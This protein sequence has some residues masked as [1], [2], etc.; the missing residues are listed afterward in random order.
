MKSFYGKNLHKTINK[1]TKWKFIPVTLC[2]CTFASLL[3]FSSAAIAGGT[4]P[5]DVRQEINFNKNWKFINGEQA[6]AEA[7]TFDDSE[8]QAVRLP[9]DW[10]IAGPFDASADGSTGKLPWR[11]A[12]WYRKTF[13]L[14]EADSGKR[15]YFNFDGVMAFPKVYINGQLA[16]QWDYGYTP[17][18]IDATNHVKFGQKNTIAVMVD[19]RRHNSRWYPGAGIYRD[20]TMVICSQVHVEHWGT[21]VTAPYVSDKA[22]SV[23]VRNTIENHLETDSLADIDV[24]LFAPDGKE[25]VKKSS[26]LT[27]PAGGSKDIVFSFNV[28]NPQI[29]DV[30]S[31]KLYSAKTIVRLGETNVDIGT[32]TFGIRTFEFTPDNG[33]QLNGRRLQL[34]GVCLHHDLGPLGSAFNMRAMEREL[35]IMKEMGVNAIRTSHNPPAKGLIE[36]CNKM[37]LVVIDEAFDKWDGTADLIGNQT[38][39]KEHGERHLRNLVMRDRN[40]PSV[41][42]WS[43]GNEIGNLSRSRPGNGKSAENV[44]MMSDIVRKYDP[45]RPVGI[46]EDK[47]DS[48]RDL[49]LDSLDVVGFNYSKRYQQFRLANPNIPLFYSESASALSTRGFYS[50]PLPS[51]KTQYD[52]QAQQVSSYDLNAAAWSD[53]PDVEFFT[54]VDDNFLAGEF[55]WT[56]FDYIGEPT[57]FTRQAKSSY[58][59]IVDLSGLPKDRYYLYRSHWRPDTATIHILPHWNWPDR[60]G[61][62]VPVFVYTNGDSAELFLNGKSLG[63]RTKKTEV[64]QNVN[65]VTGKTVQASSQQGTNTGSMANDGNQNTAWRAEGGGSQWWQVDLGTVMPIGYCSI[66]FAQ[67][68]SQAQTQP[69]PGQRR[70]FG[71]PA[72]NPQYVIKTSSDGNKWQD[73]ASSQSDVQPQGRAGRGGGFGGMGGFGGGFGGGT[74]HEFEAN[75]RY[76]RIEFTSSQDGVNGISEF[77]LNTMSPDKAYYNVTGLYRLMWNDVTYEPGQLKVVAYKE[78]KTIGEAVMKTAGQPAKLKLTPDRNVIKADGCDLSY[79]L[80]EMIDADGNLCP[81]ADNTVNFTADGQIEIAAVGNGNPLSIEPFMA[82]SRKLFYGKAMLILR[83]IEGKTGKATV[84]ASCDGLPD[85]TVTV[86]CQ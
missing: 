7:I 28:D 72:S 2:V 79:V 11:G 26:Y 48:A 34:H 20:V 29:W 81:L 43:I 50:F 25:L 61:Q 63:K 55:V 21:F 14:N 39:L 71:Q 16:G 59:G 80:V 66:S 27:V 64:S 5:S 82:N 10:A 84:K 85:T 58:F 13:T 49:I 41:I 54:M 60:L 12:G 35:E 65:L 22:A 73:L 67:A 42:V 3:I 1:N 19:T 6:G 70:G 45:T 56:G 57:P 51:G 9:H 36:I 24:V 78:G 74:R 47:T 15:V 75:A 8:W 69:A 68:Q 17:F 40:S 38:S 46:G 83:S 33:F 4:S 86:Q 23:R 44:T 53:I 37:G 76:V 77:I 62:N 52:Q 18:W 31:P 30:I 32:S